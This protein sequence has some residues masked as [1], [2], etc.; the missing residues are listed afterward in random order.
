MNCETRLDQMKFIFQPGVKASVSAIMVHFLDAG[1]RG[2]LII[3]HLTTGR[4]IGPLVANSDPRGQRTNVMAD[5]KFNCSHCGQDIECD[6][7]WSGHEIQCPT[8]QGQLVVPP[9]PEAAPH[10]T[11]AN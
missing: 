9:K 4:R 11:L 7:L 10:A 8:C 5:M 1:R 2:C 3:A 6:E